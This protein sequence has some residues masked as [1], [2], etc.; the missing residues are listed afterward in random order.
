MEKQ[1]ITD[2]FKKQIFIENY[3]D[4]TI[5]NYLSA[6]KLFFEWIEK[7]DVN[8]VTNEEIQ[9]YLFYCKNEKKYAFSTMEQI[10]ATISFLYVKV[11]DKPIT[12]AL[13]IKL[14]KPTHLPN[15]FQLFVLRIPWVYLFG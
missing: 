11:L 3:S 10:I 1:K 15:V 4:Q 2:K 9:D 6:L 13:D 12:K 5:K 8:K 7:S 14:R